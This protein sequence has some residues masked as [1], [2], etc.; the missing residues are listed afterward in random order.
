M[1]V[2]RARSDYD[3]AV[4][5]INQLDNEIDGLERQIAGLRAR[6]SSQAAARDEALTRI[7]QSQSTVTGLD[8]KIRDSQM[9]IRN[10]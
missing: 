3:S 1:S 4:N 2:T 5:A 8:D 7:T 10:L 6:K 9:Q